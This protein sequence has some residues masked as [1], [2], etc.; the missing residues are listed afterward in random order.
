MD[1]RIKRFVKYALTAAVG[2]VMASLVV[3][4]HGFS[5]AADSTERMRILADAFTIPDVVLLCFGLLV[6][7]SNEG[8]FDG[9]AYAV[10]YAVNMLIP[11]SHK[12]FERY[13]DYLEHKHAKGKARGFGFLFVI[14]GIYLAAGV[15]FTVLFYLI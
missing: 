7:V 2:A 10:R 9:I 12:K 14:G 6:V 8:I 1:D 5:A 4:L 11:G 13:A 15:L 3:D